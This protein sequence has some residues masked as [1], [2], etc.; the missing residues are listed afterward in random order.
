[1]YARYAHV[2][3]YM[4]SRLPRSWKRSRVGSSPAGRGTR[5][6]APNDPAATATPKAAPASIWPVPTTRPKPLE[7]QCGVSEAIQSTAASEI[8]SA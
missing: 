8:V 3:T 7:Y 1:M 2:S 6:S 4:S 5:A